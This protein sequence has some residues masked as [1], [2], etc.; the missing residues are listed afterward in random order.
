MS[1]G[2]RPRLLFCS[3]HS[4]WDPSS[5]AAVSTRDLLEMLAARG[6][7]CGVLCGPHLDYERGRP[8]EQVLRARGV[9][10]QSAR[11]TAGGVAYTLHHAIANGVPL[12]LYTPDGGKTYGRPGEAEGRTFL[13]LFD[14]VCGHFR[15][16]VVLTYG[17][18]WL[19]RAAIERAK[20]RGLKVVFTL[21]NFAYRDA[22]LFQSVDAIIVPSRTAREHYQRTL[23]IACTVLP[24]PFDPARV[25][26][27][28]GERRYVVF[29]NPQPDKGVFVF[30]R[31]ADELGRR[32]PDVP[33]LTIEGRGGAEWLYRT[34]LDLARH[35]NLHVM[36]NTP[37]PRD[38]Y[39]LARVVLMPSL[40]RESFARVP[41][42]AMLNGIP[43]LASRRGG[44][45][46]TLAE[47][48]FLF[49]VPER[50]T[51]EARELPTAEEVRP[52]LETLERLWD[53]PGF[54]AAEQ[55]RALRAAEA[56]RPEQLLPRCEE[57]FRAVAAGRA[58]T[59]F[60]DP[61]TARAGLPRLC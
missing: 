38:F 11:A 48:G 17:G 24:G 59:P 7:A 51:P 49:D 58:L 60:G 52:W 32:R 6:W 29:V 25:L 42:E 46:E 37:D 53:D 28:A 55:A 35:P 31:I 39:R 54:Y 36:A 8:P 50:C 16:D 27:P 47:A 45:P 22:S 14:R 56:W 12:T 9:P 33:L 41:V 2:P 4:F 40:W 10:V 5:G 23:G 21:R 3:Y 1:E 34:G 43:V 13:Q 61:A 30:A 57:F 19:A 15:P 18:H 44:L 26:C 20:Q